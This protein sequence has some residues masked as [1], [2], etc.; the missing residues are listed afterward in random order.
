MPIITSV[1]GTIAGFAG[2]IT[3]SLFVAKAV[4]WSL[5]AGALFAANALLNR[6]EIP[7]GPPVPDR[8]EVFTSGPARWVIG[9][10]R[11]G[12][13]VM[14]WGEDWNVPE[15]EGGGGPGADD[16][17]LIVAVSEG[18]CDAV[19][20]VWVAGERLEVKF[21]DE[22]KTTYARRG[23][24]D[25]DTEAELALLPLDLDPGA[26]T[27]WDSSIERYRIREGGR[28]L[29]RDDE[30]DAELIRRADLS[31]AVNIVPYLDA[32][33][34]DRWQSVRTYKDRA[35]TA[36]LDAATPFTDW[37]S[38]HRLQGVAG[39]HIRLRQWTKHEFDER[40]FRGS[41]PDLQF[42]IRGQRLTFP[43]P[44]E[45]T[46]TITRWTN[47]AAAVR[48]W[49]HTQRRG[50]D[51][52]GID[53]AAFVA[54]YKICETK[55]TP[56]LPDTWPG[57][58][59]P[60]WAEDEETL[61][62]RR[63]SIDGLLASGDSP[64]SIE[65]EFDD[66][67]QGFVVEDGGSL[68]YYPG[69]DRADQPT[70]IDGGDIL[71]P[72]T[73]QPAPSLTE[74][75]NAV[76]LTVEQSSFHDFNTHSL[77]EIV[78]ASKRDE[79]DEGLHLPHDLGAWRWTINPAQAYSLG[80]I[81]LR[82]ARHSG[83]LSL[84]LPPGTQEDPIGYLTMSPGLVHIVN[85]PAE[86]F[87]ARRMLLLDKQISEEMVVTATFVD[88]PLGLYAPAFELPDVPSPPA[89]IPSR[90]GSRPPK[91][92]GLEVSHSAQVSNDG[93][94]YFR[95]EASVNDSPLRK[96]FRLTAG[97]DQWEVETAS[98][99]HLFSVNV[100]R[101]SMGITV[102]HIDKAGVLSLPVR[103]NFTPD[104]AKVVLPRPIWEDVIVYGG[105]L[106]LVF[107]RVAYGSSIS[108]V[109]VRYTRLP[110]GST[111]SL[112]T[113]TEANWTTAPVLRTEAVQI[114]RELDVNVNAIATQ[115]GRY[116]LFARFVSQVSGA[117]PVRGPLSYLREVEIDI[118]EQPITTI[119]EAPLFAGSS[120]HL[121]KWIGTAGDA[122]G[123]SL[124]FP[125]HTPASG[126]RFDRW[127]GYVPN[128]SIT[129][130]TLP[131]W[132][133]GQCE[134]F[135]STLDA[136][137]R[138]SFGV[139]TGGGSTWYLTAPVDLGV[140]K[141]VE[142]KAEIFAY[143]PG[144]SRQSNLTFGTHDIADQSWS[145]GAI[146]A[147]TLPE[148]SQATGSI[149][150]SLQGL[151]AGLAFAPATRIV[152]GSPLIATAT[153]KARYV[154][155]DGGGGEAVIEFGW[156]ISSSVSAP[157][158][159]TGLAVSAQ[160]TTARLTWTPAT[161]A[162]IYEISRATSSTGPWTIVGASVEP[163]EDLSGLTANTAYYVRVRA[164]NGGGYS[165]YSSALSFTT[166]AIR[167]APATPVGL[168]EEA[169]TSTSI[170]VDWTSANG[171]TS[172]EVRWKD[173]NLNTYDADDIAAA[174]TS[175]E[176][177]IS[178]L[179]TA[180]AYDI[181]VRARNA[182]GV[183]AWS[184]AVEI[185]TLAATF[186]APSIS[187][188][189]PVDA[190]RDYLQIVI[191]SYSNLNSV[192]LEVTA[193]PP[194]GVHGSL[195]R[196]YTESPPGPYQIY[197]VKP[198]VT[199]SVRARAILQGGAK[200]QWSAASSVVFGQ[201]PSA[202][203]SLS[204]TPS[205]TFVTLS[206]SAPA[207]GTPTSYRVEYHPA[208]T[209]SN[210]LFVAGVTGTSQTITGL[211][212]STA[213]TFEVKAVNAHGASLAASVDATTTT[214][215]LTAPLAPSNRRAIP[216]SS[217]SALLVWSSASTAATYEVR[218]SRLGY[219]EF[220]TIVGGLTGLSFDFSGLTPSH[221]LTFQIR[222]RN[223]A[224]VSSWANFTTIT[225]P[226]E[227]ASDYDFDSSAPLT[228]TRGTGRLLAYS[229]TTT[230]DSGVA[231]F[232][233]R[234]RQSPDS[235]TDDNV[236]PDWQILS[237]T[238]ANSFS[239][240]QRTFTGSFDPGFSGRYYE[241]QVRAY[242][243][244]AVGSTVG[245]SSW[246]PCSNSETLTNPSR[247]LT[248]TIRA[249]AVAL[250]APV[251][252]F[253]QRGR[254]AIRVEAHIDTSR[255]Q[256]E[257]GGGVFDV[258]ISQ[259]NG[260]PA[261]TYD[262]NFIYKRKTTYG[263]SFSGYKTGSVSRWNIN[264]GDVLTF[265]NTASET[266]RTTVTTTSTY[267]VLDPAANPA[268]APGPVVSIAVERE[269]GSVTF[270]WPEV[271][272]ADGYEVRVIEEDVGSLDGTIE[273]A[274]QTG[275]GLE[276][277][278]IGG[279]NEHF[280]ISVRAYK[281]SGAGR[282]FSS[283]KTHDYSPTTD[284]HSVGKVTGL[285]QDPINDTTR[286]RW[287]AVPNADGYE[288]QTTTNEG[289]SAAATTTLLFHVVNSSGD[290]T[291][292][293]RAYRGSGQSRI[294][295]LAWSALA[296]KE[297]TDPSAG[298]VGDVESVVAI[299]RGDDVVFDWA[300][301]VNAGRYRIERASGN[302]WVVVQSNI[303]SNTTAWDTDEDA[304]VTSKF[305]IR[306][307]TDESNGAWTVLDWTAS[308][309]LPLGS[310]SSVRLIASQSSITARWDFPDGIYQAEVEYRKGSTGSWSSVSV[311][312]Y[313]KHVVITGLDD[314]SSYQV[315]A[316]AK[317][318]ERVGAWTTGTAATL[319]CVSLPAPK[320]LT[321]SIKPSSSGGGVTASWAE[322]V[323]AKWYDIRIDS[324][325][326]QSGPWINRRSNATTILTAGAGG[327]RA[328]IY[329][330]VR[331]RTVGYSDCDGDWTTAI[332]YE[333]TQQ[334]SGAA[335][336]AEGAIAAGTGA[337]VSVPAGL[338]EETPVEPVSALARPYFAGYFE[339]RC[340]LA[341]S[342]IDPFT[343]PATDGGKPPRTITIEDLPAGLVFD[344]GTRTISGTPSGTAPSE[345]YSIVRLE[346]SN[347][348]FDT[349]S[350]RW[351]L[352]SGVPQTWGSLP[353]FG[354]LTNPFQIECT[355]KGNIRPFYFRQG[356]T[357]AGDIVSDA[358]NA[359]N[360]VLWLRCPT[361]YAHTARLL[362]AA[363]PDYDLVVKVGDEFRFSDTTDDLEF[364]R[365]PGHADGALIGV[366][367][368]GATTATT[369]VNNT[370]EPLIV[371][372]YPDVIEAPGDSAG[373]EASG[374]AGAAQPASVS[375]AT[376]RTPG[377][378]ET[379]VYLLYRNGKTGAW[380]R[381]ST[382]LAEGW[383]DV[384][385]NAREIRF[386]YHLKRWENRAVRRITTFHRDR[387]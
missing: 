227:A 175:S 116:G 165:A 48:Y 298:Q 283:A 41:V 229:L 305:R 314:D 125:S 225:I 22:A 149:V 310:I 10:R 27:W 112:P 161:N 377:M 92:S 203:R 197:N 292:R 349:R 105:S 198:G 26:P 278:K 122:A 266:H 127:N 12:G 291:V 82:R 340:V 264:A 139:L 13:V 72:P 320:S 379:E 43:N 18:T 257:T 136:S 364:V 89:H 336:S 73:W 132:P 383:T 147:I 47:N 71:E 99:S 356:E 23:A 38:D 137:G 224:G 351:I 121:F 384:G 206:W 374:A 330:R 20:A 301:A 162:G 211:D 338:Y 25:G 345:S 142:V 284:A 354:T 316:R 221:S 98:N 371:E 104:Y 249:G 128:S 244:A 16:L 376:G 67:W 280:R 143:T 168:A 196:T 360:V 14:Y 325:T 24:R 154:A 236:V 91:P 220:F 386:E 152:S 317:A 68:F 126:L 5:K 380:S 240:G 63:Y 53:R 231:H 274:A 94:V 174:L 282:L 311:D 247:T 366:Y 279:R 169:K 357:N 306:G 281:G 245:L 110:L 353:G 321:L 87:E 90:I 318:G 158:T 6:R 50:I 79:V 181:Q 223:A 3:N 230:V 344:A 209:P 65:A 328:P 309:L 218:Y 355:T 138:D 329:W 77:R 290:F 40:V 159:P 187:S 86:G 270:S 331:V 215:A 186:A 111:T 254:G 370:G 367:R 131:R 55:I 120:N 119:E 369:G 348:A 148:A 1:F 375:A 319:E 361:T 308:T 153:G 59:T 135:G 286:I 235:K 267:T 217:S 88:A 155:T 363:S 28:L 191:G 222:S 70:E 35:D 64:S 32:D 49:W 343:L 385:T 205:T 42:L 359:R 58:E 287:R 173:A 93:S 358:T 272:G 179:G 242:V 195:P 239:S 133:F 96:V 166:A 261:S 293:I 347:G 341:G 246:H 333:P 332:A 362:G 83:T 100:P 62:F 276:Y 251:P 339:E 262:S 193:D 208:A 177:T 307:E 184:A 372:W 178:G 300:Q 327:V 167:S 194:D 107:E 4:Y 226:P 106:R 337:S 54:A 118:P 140:S 57:G 202:P 200:S 69:A 61:S 303:S 15:T 204:A 33:A 172:Y 335:A 237:A 183:S 188:L 164:Q 233:I 297:F 190:V 259:V 129:S 45:D 342:A 78:D 56:S 302:D 21:T 130:G 141:R 378:T 36:V 76:T 288:I 315:R 382:P 277:E 326:T 124:L 260:A 81:T 250:T 17:H 9:R 271:P 258:D 102:R 113:L 248:S 115:S 31:G 171:V 145:S 163:A 108:G 29:D 234:F 19:E 182:A 117:E 34:S 323:G 180:S 52:V 97:D 228:M 170:T 144:T 46:G 151:P 201:V 304:S 101:M 150:Y 243:D 213:Y 156:S 295:G 114:V 30:D 299:D 241:V 285:E 365:V 324:S 214:P 39:L 268:T 219:S 294:Y 74:R 146:A 109:E 312:R 95:I 232:Q 352:A 381:L 44:D 51:A 8:L 134:G 157:G 189:T 263:F 216:I 207:T 273:Y 84:A 252:A 334:S 37:T 176:H 60:E 253:F 75:T 322:V 199:Y 80:T 212:S 238:I 256:F 275:A 103:S 269:D 387:A 85:I 350:I 11:V 2:A 296:H 265:T 373:D 313:S 255:S 192:E 160:Q 346:D 66:A 210:V 7:D 368:Y 289:W 123:E 185:T